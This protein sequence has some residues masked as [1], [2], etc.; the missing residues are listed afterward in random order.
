MGG[1]L[2]IGT[3]RRTRLPFPSRVFEILVCAI[4]PA[5]KQ[6]TTPAVRTTFV[7]AFIPKITD[8]AMIIIHPRDQKRIP[9]AINHLFLTAAERKLRNRTGV[10]AWRTRFVPAQKSPGQCRGF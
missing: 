4:A 7:I 5:V 10:Q 1:V 2:F 3:L 9:V 8:R 6:N